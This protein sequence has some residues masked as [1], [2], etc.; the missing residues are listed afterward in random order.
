[1]VAYVDLLMIA[2]TSVAS[3]DNRA[4]PVSTAEMGS[5][6]PPF[7]V[8]EDASIF[9]ITSADAFLMILYSSSSYR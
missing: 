5:A 4:N 9:A 2:H 7:A 6:L 1:M 3:S 8:S